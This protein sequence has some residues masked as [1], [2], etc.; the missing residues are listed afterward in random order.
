MD[1]RPAPPPTWQASL[2]ANLARYL[3]FA[4]AQTR[5]PASGISLPHYNALQV[6]VTT[7]RLR[8]VAELAAG[9]TPEARRDLALGFR[10]RGG[11]DHDPSVIAFLVDGTRVSTLMQPIW[12]GLEKRQ[13]SAGD[14]D[15][16]QGE[17]RG[18]N[19]L[20][21]FQRGL[22]GDRAFWEAAWPEDLQNPAL[23][24]EI[25]R[26]MNNPEPS[27]SSVEGAIGRVLP[28]L[29]RGWFEQNAALA[30]RCLQTCGIDN[31]DPVHLL[32][33][34]AR[35]REGDRQIQTIPIWLTTILARTSV[36]PFGS[37]ALK[38]AQFQ[39]IVHQAV[40]A[41][42]LEK[43]ALDHQTYPA[44][45]AA[46]VP[47]YLDRVPDDVIDGAPMRYCLMVDGRYKLWSVG[48]NGSDEGGAIAWPPN[49]TWRRAHDPAATGQTQKLPTPAKDQG[50]WVWQ[51]APAEPPDPPANQSR[52]D[53]L[54]P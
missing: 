40:A 51:Y 8:A 37:L 4:R 3:L 44:A 5:C 53:S 20:H 9:Q 24:R 41:C 18:I 26:D 15:A 22:R 45:L 17:L 43:Y 2:Q 11:M 7:L 34:P 35:S 27:W 38:A 23:V 29:P 12:E 19:F 49:R 48:W 54:P 50:D 33:P 14:L 6:L 16:L 46:L 28:Y 25:S 32:V 10:L 39:T 31:V 52:L 36:A 1:P 30:C 21:E 42:A 47:S 13:W